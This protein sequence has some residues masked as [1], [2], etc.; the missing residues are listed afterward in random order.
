[1]VNIL[2][3]SGFG[4]GTSFDLNLNNIS[5][6]DAF[7]EN[8]AGDITLDKNL[9]LYKELQVLGKTTVSDLSV[10]GDLNTGLIKTDGVKA[11]INAIA[12]ILKLQDLYGAGNIE[13]FGGKIVMTT[14]GNIHL[15]GEVTASKYN[16]ETTNPLTASAGEAIIVAGQNTVTVQTS[17]LTDK[18]LIFVT[19]ERPVLIGARKTAADEFA[20]DLN[21]SEKSDLKVNWWVVN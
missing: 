12:S 3:Y 2:W 18:S 21:K 1:M 6:N 10:T 8:T 17:A 16:I 13:A 11:S 14:G 5:A 7:S 19:P 9:V 4:Q 20:I 15:L